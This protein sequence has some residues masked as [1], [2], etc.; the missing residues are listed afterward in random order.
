MLGKLA[1]LSEF[2]G[3]HCEIHTNA[4]LSNLTNLV[5]PSKSEG[6]K[7]NPHP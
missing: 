1:K 7:T 3:N 5:M 4:N 2:G 6:K